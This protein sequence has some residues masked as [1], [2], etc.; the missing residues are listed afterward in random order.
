MRGS[1]KSFI[2]NRSIKSVGKFVDRKFKNAPLH[3]QVEAMRNLIATAAGVPGSSQ[4]KAMRTVRANLL[5]KGGLPADI[6]GMAKKGRTQGQIKEYYWSCPEF[7][8]FWT[9]DLDMQEETLDE[10]IRGAVEGT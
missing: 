10:L 4:E 9:N 6:R 3:K 7:V 1:F 2:E 8:Q 5:K